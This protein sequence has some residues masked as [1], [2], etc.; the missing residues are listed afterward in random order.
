MNAALE[1]FLTISRLFDLRNHHK[2]LF[3]RT[4]EHSCC[5]SHLCAVVMETRQ[6]RCGGDSDCTA[7]V[8]GTDGAVV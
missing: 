1:V 8:G 6:H 5:T 2:H 4:R 7:G 3:L